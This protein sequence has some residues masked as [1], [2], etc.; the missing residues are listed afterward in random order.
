MNFIFCFIASI[1]GIAG[2]LYAAPGLA[3]LV[4]REWREALQ[5]LG[6]SSVFLGIYAATWQFLPLENWVILPSG[7]AAILS[8]FV[9][10]LVLKK[11][12]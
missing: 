2:C 5:S 8:A 6:I 12:V 4:R 3:L 11:G 9:F 1:V 10:A 7:I